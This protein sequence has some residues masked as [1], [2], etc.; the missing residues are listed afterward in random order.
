MYPEWSRRSF[1]QGSRVGKNGVICLLEPMSV[2]LTSLHKKW[3]DTS[4]S[5]IFLIRRS[6]KKELNETRLK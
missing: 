4:L 3:Q 1:M 2:C 6:D 5:S